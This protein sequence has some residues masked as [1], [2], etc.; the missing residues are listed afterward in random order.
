MNS[1]AHPHSSTAERKRAHA[2]D[3][4]IVPILEPAPD[5][6]A[7]RFTKLVGCE[8]HP[9]VIFFG[10]IVAGL[11][12]L[13]GS[14]VLIGMLITHVLVHTAGIGD[15]NRHVETWLASHRTPGRTEASLIGSI[16]AGG[17]VLPIVVG[18]LGIAFAALKQWRIAAFFVFGLMLESGSYRVTTIFFHEHRPRVHRLETLPVNAAY[19]SGHTAASIAVYAGLVLLLTS[20]FTNVGF[21]ICAWTIAI[22]IPVFVALSRMYRGMHYPLDVTGGALLGI[23][24]LTVMVFACRASGAAARHRAADR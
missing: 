14:S 12:L 10:A 17:V 22:A 18:V 19:P 4:W 5:G 9:V 11:I 2:D 6:P 24:S 13:A 7:E 8:R 21:R 23:A 1:V 3:R 20:R 15:A 16:M